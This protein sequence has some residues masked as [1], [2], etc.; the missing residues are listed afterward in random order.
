MDLMSLVIDHSVSLLELSKDNIY[1]ISRR[2]FNS[3]LHISLA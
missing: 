2:S 1:S 3:S